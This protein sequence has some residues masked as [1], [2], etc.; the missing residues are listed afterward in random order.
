VAFTPD[1]AGPVRRKGE[2]ERAILR[3]SH[4]E[5]E[6]WEEDSS[7][8]PFELGPLERF[9][10]LL[11]GEGKIFTQ[12]KWERKRRGRRGG[13]ACMK[14]RSWGKKNERKKSRDFGVP[15]FSRGK[16]DTPGI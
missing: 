5:G 8:N 13:G 2:R 14:Y 1:G 16:N 7:G 12:R 10:G 15:S 11:K 4:L 6:M 9:R 3:L